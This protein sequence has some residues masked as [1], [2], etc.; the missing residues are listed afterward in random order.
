MKKSAAVF[1]LAILLLPLNAFSNVVEFDR[2]VA[3][4]NND[5]ITLSELNREINT[6]KKQFASKQNSLPPDDIL[7]KQLLERLIVKRLQ[8][9]MAP[10]IAPSTQLSIPVV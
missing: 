7:Q 10:G 5:I 9:E 2:V 4:V 8:L 6:I 3:V 1:L